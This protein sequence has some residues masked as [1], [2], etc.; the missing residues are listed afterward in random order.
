MPRPV[1]QRYCASAPRSR[2]FKPRGIPLEDLT[3]ATLTI[4]EFEA[5]RLADLLG[6]SQEEA[7]AM[8]NISR[9]TFGRIVERARRTVAD[10]LVHG[11]ALAI[12]GGEVI[13][14]RHAHVRCRNCRHPWDVPA[15]V[16]DSF[17]C[18]HCQK[19][20]GEQQQ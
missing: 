19:N 8:M 3:L 16:A 13:R 6:H 1:K 9:A 18:P 15:P 10:A 4:D 14:T 17:R 12:E 5:L 11:H 2:L 7:A 20:K